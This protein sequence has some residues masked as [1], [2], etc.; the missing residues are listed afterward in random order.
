MNDGLWLGIM[1]LHSGSRCCGSAA[2]SRAQQVHRGAA[3]AARAWLRQLQGNAE[4]R[5]CVRA[6]SRPVPAINFM[7]LNQNRLN[8]AEPKPAPT[9]PRGGVGVDRGWGWGFVVVVVVVV[10]RQ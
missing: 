1:E 3:R 2:R 7:R 10:E 4:R 8:G 5:A 6:Y 9:P